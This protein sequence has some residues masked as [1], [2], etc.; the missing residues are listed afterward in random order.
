MFDNGDKSGAGDEKAGDGFYSLKNSF[1]KTAQTGK[2]RFEF[3]AID[4]A[5]SLSNKIIHELLVK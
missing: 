5:D 3:R 1:G 4:K 2:W